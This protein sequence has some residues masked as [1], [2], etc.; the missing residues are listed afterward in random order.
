MISKIIFC[1]GVARV[2]EVLALDQKMVPPPGL[3]SLCGG[4]PESIIIWKD[5]PHDW[6]YDKDEFD[7]RRDEY[8][9]ECCAIERKNNEVVPK[10]PNCCEGN[11]MQ[12][13]DN[14][15][16]Y[17]DRSL[18]HEDWWYWGD[19]WNQ[20]IASGIRGSKSMGRGLCRDGNHLDRG[21]FCEDYDNDEALQKDYAD[22]DDCIQRHCRKWCATKYSAPEQG[23]NRE[24]CEYFSWSRNGEPENCFLFKDRCN[25]VE[26]EPSQFPRYS[27]K[28]QV[29]GDTWETERLEEI[30]PAGFKSFTMREFNEPSLCIWVPDSGDKKV[31]VMIETEMVDA[32]I[33]IRDG[34]DMGMG[35]NNEVG[36]VETCNKGRLEACFTA[37][38]PTTDNKNWK[39]FFFLVYCNGSCEASDVDFWLRIRKSRISWDAG[40]TSTA[41]DIEMW[42]EMEKGS[43]ALATQ[44]IKASHKETCE[45]ITKLTEVET[46]RGTFSTVQEKCD[47]TENCHWK[48]DGGK[49]KAGIWKDEYTWPSELTQDEP[50][51]D[52]IDIQHVL[53]LSATNS[54]H[55]G[56]LFMTII[57]LAAGFVWF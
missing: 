50:D 15:A 3:V 21:K 40:K 48:E 37:A 22:I 17:E 27:N 18:T 43:Q 14:E 30:Y 53:E 44:L 38:D 1:L 45:A 13:S 25:R 42:C 5:V 56:L 33:C 49:C 23:A 16:N 10:V 57:T 26:E 4:N 28:E 6:N 46:A 2:F 54:L 36:N 11:G 7:K 51:T 41:D 8:R 24:R 31:E 9:R 55:D 47:L 35:R 34:S 12:S 39:D 20:L 32:E 19:D 52:P 29:R